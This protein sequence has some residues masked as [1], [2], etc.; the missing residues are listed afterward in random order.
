MTIT[1]IPPLEPFAAHLGNAFFVAGNGA[2][3]GTAERTDRLGADCVQ[4]AI[5]ELAADFH[6]VGFRRAIS[7]R[8]ALDHV[9]DVDILAQQG[10][11]FLFRSALDHLREQ[12]AGTSDE[13]N[14]LLVLVGA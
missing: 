9:A 3:G 1:G 7:R 4:L 14:A 10:N 11:A 12:L 2:R 8:A 6:L 13:G 5:E